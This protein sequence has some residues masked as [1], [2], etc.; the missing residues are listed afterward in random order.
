MAEAKTFRELWKLANDG[1]TSSGDPGDRYHHWLGCALHGNP[2]DSAPKD[3]QA[4]IVAALER[5]KD[6]R[7]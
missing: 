6:S 3:V 1:R 7:P 2:Y 4:A 5:T